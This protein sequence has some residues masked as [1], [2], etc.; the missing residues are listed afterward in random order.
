MLDVHFVLVGA[1]VGVIGQG[2]YI[3]DTLR[4]TTKPNR[5]TYLLWGVAPLLAFSVELHAGVGLRSLTTLVVSLGPLA[6]LVASFANGA[7]PWK[8]SRLDYVCGLVSVAGTAAWL[9][10][11][12]GTIALVAA[13]AADGLAAVPTVVKSWHHPET[14]SV[15]LYAGGVVNAG[16]LLLTVQRVTL[17]V[18]AFPT[19]IVA[20]GL[21]QV[22]LVGRIRWRPAPA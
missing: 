17:T 7:A 3:R 16:L 11:R 14:E 21:L 5:V 1:A 10:S 12:H 9:I 8:I 15:S 2:L 22:V 19:Y 13:I 20:V 6:I 18:V 4:G